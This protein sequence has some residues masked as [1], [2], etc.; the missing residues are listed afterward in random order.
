MLKEQNKKQKRRKLKLKMQH[1]YST[2]K[3]T[4]REMRIHPRAL[5]TKPEK[6]E[7]TL[8]FAL[9]WNQV[10]VM[11]RNKDLMKPNKSEKKNQQ[12]NIKKEEKRK[13]ISS[14]TSKGRKIE[15]FLMKKYTNQNIFPSLTYLKGQKV[16]EKKSKKA[17][18]VLQRR[19]WTATLM[20]HLA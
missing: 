3:T 6:R 8:H 20:G 5:W 15:P 4:T 10:Y 14:R 19:G 7:I 17:R 1:D 2:P 18:C 11:K 12:E 9:N 13:F 16:R